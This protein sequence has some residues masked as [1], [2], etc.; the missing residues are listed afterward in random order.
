M[1]LPTF[2]WHGDDAW[3]LVRRHHSY[4]A[5]K[6]D[7]MDDARHRAGDPP[8]PPEIDAELEKDLREQIVMGTP[9]DVADHIRELEEAAG[10]ISTSSLASTTRG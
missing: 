9:E 7:D 2:A 8:E 10:A 1:H 4:V 3:E 5:W 6:Y